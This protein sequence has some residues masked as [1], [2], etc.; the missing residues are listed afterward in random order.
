MTLRSVNSPICCCCIFSHPKNKK[1]KRSSFPA[2]TWRL[3]RLPRVTRGRCCANCNLAGVWRR[4]LRADTVTHRVFQLPRPARRHDCLIGSVIS[5]AIIMILIMSITAALCC[6][7]WHQMA[8]ARAFFFFP[9]HPRV[10]DACLRCALCL[11]YYFFFFYN[12][13]TF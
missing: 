13:K 6:S 8:A 4:P 2:I 3:A 7:V 10:S 12:G 5:V 11:F 9:P 1:N